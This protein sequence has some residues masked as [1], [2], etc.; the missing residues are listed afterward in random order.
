M[1]S[2]TMGRIAG[3]SGVKRWQGRVAVAL[4]FL[5]GLLF[6]L[7]HLHW[8]TAARPIPCAHVDCGHHGLLVAL[9]LAWEAGAPVGMGSGAGRRSPDR[10]R[11]PD[12]HGTRHYHGRSN[13][14]VEWGCTV[15]AWPTLIAVSCSDW[16]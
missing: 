1:A 2:I 7:A 6:A 15:K 14:N 3:V 13:A 16:A 11:D 10:R 12:V 8:T 9:E 4:A 5:I